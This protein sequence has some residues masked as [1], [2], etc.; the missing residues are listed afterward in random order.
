MPIHLTN[1][2][3]RFPIDMARLRARAEACLKHLG[4]DHA[5]LSVLLV[6]DRAMRRLNR[7]F[8]GINRPTD[9]LSFPMF[10]GSPAVVAATVAGVA[11]A[12]AELGD[13]VISVET[14]HRQAA[15]LGIPEDGELALL[16][17][18]GTLHLLGYDHETG[19][20]GAARMAAE[21]GRL[22]TA[23]G[24]THPGLI[25]RADG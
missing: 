12:H 9:V 14:A 1:R 3:R 2:Q 7:D 21:E 24:L 17:A 25:A 6:N 10:E 5:T 13:V 4:I 20:A 18:H 8:R 15:A 11:E 23:L 22:L 16:L 19:P